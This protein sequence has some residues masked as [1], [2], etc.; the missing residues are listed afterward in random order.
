VRIC[1]VQFLCEAASVPQLVAAFVCHAVWLR[2]LHCTADKN[3]PTI[4]LEPGENAAPEELSYIC[5][6]VGAFS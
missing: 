2:R 1:D 5:G 6:S 3:R 4:V